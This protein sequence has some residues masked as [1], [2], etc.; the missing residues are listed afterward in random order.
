[1]EN[2]KKDQSEVSSTR[3]ALL[4]SAKE[5][6][7]DKGYSAV[8]T[9]EIA[10]RASVNLG[11]I[12]YHFGSKARLFVETVRQLMTERH[13]SITF[14]SP[15]EEVSSGQEAAVELCLFIRAFL[16]DLC[17]PKGPDVCRI[18]HREINGVTSQDP[19]MFEALVVSVT[20]EFIRPLDDRLMELITMLRPSAS[21]EEVATLAQ[22]VIGQCAF[23]H[24]HRP[25]AN[26][27]RG[28]ELT[29]HDNLKNIANDISQFTLRGLGLGEQEIIDAVATAANRGE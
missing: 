25:F 22:S 10:E 2:P 1:V 28:K 29:G 23:Y 15:A 24:T 3:K 9:R 14:F 5:L 12:T 13:K 20:E 7:T 27:L 19:D 4:S 16:N 21:A 11:A 6:F 18:M 8:S 17:H 26:R